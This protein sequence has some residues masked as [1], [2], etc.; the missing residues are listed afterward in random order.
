MESSI[1]ELHCIHAGQL[2]GTLALTL[3]KDL[4]GLLG[5]LDTAEHHGTKGRS[6]AVEAVD[7]RQLHPTDDQALGDL[8]GI[9]D[10]GILGR[11]HVEAAHATQLVNSVHRHE[12]LRA[13][14]TKG[15][16]VAG[17]ADDHGRIDGVGVHAG[18]VVV[19]QGDEGPV[20]DHA[21]DL[22]VLG[23][24]AGGGPGDQILDGGGVEEL[25]VGEGE[26]LGQQG[27]GE[28]GGVLDHDVVGVRRVFFVGHANLIEEDL[29]RTTQ[30]HGGEKLATEPGTT[31]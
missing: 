24:T 1:T 25:D 29:G 15:A 27:G 28:E 18:V 22:G 17:G 9:L 12:P 21:G 10:N 16:V 19:V 2:L 30:D 20:D 14:G 3:V 31:T 23:V 4:K 11:V 6:H 5:S 13:K 7:L 26:D 8:A